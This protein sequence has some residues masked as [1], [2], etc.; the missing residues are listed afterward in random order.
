M[1]NAGS[2]VWG[3]SRNGHCPVAETLTAETSSQTKGVGFCVVA[4]VL[5]GMSL[6]QHG[7]EAFASVG[8]AYPHM[9]A[10]ACCLLEALRLTRFAHAGPQR[11]RDGNRK[12]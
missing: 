1:W 10:E 2:N 9:T 5:P 4:D 8:F 6:L 12:R 11:A 7:D 3:V